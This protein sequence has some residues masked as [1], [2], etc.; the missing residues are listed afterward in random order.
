MKKLF[1]ETVMNPKFTRPQMSDKLVN[2]KDGIWTVAIWNLGERNL[3]GRT[4]TEALAKR[5]VAENKTT[6]CHDGHDDYGK[7]YAGMMAYAFDPYIEDGQMCVHFQFVDKAYE[8]KILFCLEHGIPVGVSSVGYGSQDEHGV[9]GV[10]DY[11]LVRYF[12]FVNSPANETY[13]AK[14]STEVKP[15]TETTVEDSEATAA[16]NRRRLLALHQKYNRR[17]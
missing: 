3:N 9:I 1:T 11:E 13:V 12:D 2:E 4:Y 17:S 14:D 7:E 10:E 15:E 6:A 8:S 16:A 5:L